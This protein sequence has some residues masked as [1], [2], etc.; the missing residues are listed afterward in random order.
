MSVTKRMAKNFSWL[1]VGGVVS[2]GLNFL[3]AIYIA[4]VLGAASFGLLNFA[5]AFLSY[6]LLIVDA[7]LSLFGMREI[8]K[9]QAAVGRIVL[10]LL[11]VRVLVSAIS[12]LALL[13]IIYWLPVSAEMRLLFVATFL[14]IFYVALNAEWIFQ[15]LEKMEWMA[16]L[17]ILFSVACFF[18]V[19]FLVKR[20]GDL[21]RVPLI[22]FA[23]GM[24]VAT[25]GLVLLFRFIISA[26]IRRF[27]PQT[28]KTY[29][30]LALP[31]TASM[32]LTKIYTNL[33][34]IML[35]FM[36]SAAV[37]GFYNAAYKIYS[38]FIAVFGV[39]QAAAIPVATNRIHSDPARAR[40]FI[41][42]FT[43]LTLLVT[44]PFIIL[45]FLLAP[46]LVSVIFGED[47]APATLALRILIWNL[48][49]IVIGSVC[50]MLVLVPAGRFN[51]FLI[52]AGAGAV[53]NV[54]LNFL[55]IPRYS[56]AGAAVA[57]ICAETAGALSAFYF[58]RKVLKL[59]II[60]FIL[61]P[62]WLTAL[63]LIVFALVYWAGV[64]LPIYVRWFVSAIGFVVIYA[65]LLLW[66]EKNFI[67]EFAGEILGNK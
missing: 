66:T 7:G 30:V 21:I 1:L 47:Y 61:K 51:W 50:G 36:D 11:A 3:L 17:K 4:R 23:C 49:P 42:K 6:L 55:L 28:W 15:G 39:W 26:E 18:L 38:I 46:L 25:L 24:V 9:N 27:N 29:L 59:E 43:R 19:I 12:F 35:G 58:M 67:F 22:Q 54:V 34:T 37:V 31:L 40:V 63:A 14:F 44:I 41:E 65:I 5:L 64:A 45:V 2:G 57:T 48:L 53:I 10:D 20:P 13:I 60:K 33:D 56:L 32:V 16:S 52:G 62:L 8:A